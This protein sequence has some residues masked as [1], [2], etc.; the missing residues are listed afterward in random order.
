MGFEIKRFQGDVDE[1]LI[2]PICSGVLEDPLQA[3]ACE[4]AFCR[5]CITEWI[6]RQPTC[7]V[8]RQTVT[9]SQLRPVP[10]ILRNLLSRLCTSCDNAPHG[11]NAILKLDSLPNH[12][13]ECEFNP[14]R[15]IPCE[16][17]CGLVIPKDE[18]AQHNCVR[19][20]RALIAT[21]QGK[22]NDYQ[23]ELA[24]QRLVINEHKRELALLKEF[25]RAMRVSNPTMRALADQMEREEVVRWA[26]SLARARVTRWGGMISTPDDV[27]QMMIKRSLSESGCPPHIIDDLMENCHER[28]WPPGLS[29]LETRQNNR[30]LYEKYVCKRV[31][32]KQAVLVLHCDNTHVD[33]HM[34]VEP[35]LVMIFAHGIE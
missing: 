24:E 14:K 18:L 29:S 28:R 5:A 35:G 22:L 6:S 31:P 34:M 8:D 11:C 7:P 1:E 26:N 33:E 23:Q 3:P 13:V 9:A 16:A 12:L 19:E 30:R 10:R 21:Q 2:C 25:M 20:L 32:G 4:H 15:P 17:G 27:L